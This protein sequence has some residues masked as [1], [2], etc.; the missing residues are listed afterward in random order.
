MEKQLIAAIESEG[1]H[2]QRAR[3][4]DPVRKHGF[5]SRARNMGW[6]FLVKFRTMRR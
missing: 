1:T 6:K 5:L 3:P 2:V 4:F